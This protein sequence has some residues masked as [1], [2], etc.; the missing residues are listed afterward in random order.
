M[1]RH[2]QD[3][4]RTLTLEEREALEQMARAQAEPAAEVARARALLAVAEGQTY[5]AAAA[6]AGRRS[7][8]AVSELVSRFNREGLA[9][10]IPRHGGGPAVR[11]G[12]AERERI[13]AEAR[14]APEPTRDG[15]ATWSLST[16]QR[17]LREAPDGLA[18]VSTHTVWK[19]LQAA[20]WHWQK[21]RTWC[22]TG[23]VK[24]KRKCGVVE[25]TDPD[26]AAK[27]S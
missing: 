14:R 5:Q 13:L 19:V 7:N 20:G 4:L 21:T 18:Q 3:P 25:V 24:R 17:A 9:A 1:S 11:Y 26:T 6:A 16:L 2:R 12:A 15:T 22:A 8:D 10:L 27:K 23:R